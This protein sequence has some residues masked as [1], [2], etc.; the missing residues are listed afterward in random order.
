MTLRLWRR[1]RIAPG[2]RVNLSK[3]GLSLSVGPPVRM[4][5]NWPARPPGDLGMAGKRPVPG[6]AYPDHRRR[7]TSNARMKTVRFILARVLSSQPLLAL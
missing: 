7:A 2:L 4:V 3:S 5:H 1:F 6:P